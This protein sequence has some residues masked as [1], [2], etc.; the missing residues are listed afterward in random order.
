MNIA[1]A[2]YMQIITMWVA[3]IFQE[4][5]MLCLYSYHHLQYTSTAISLTSTKMLK[6][7][8]QH[9]T[10]R[11][12]A[13]TCYTAKAH[14]ILWYSYLMS[15]PSHQHVMHSTDA[16]IKI[17]TLYITHYI[18]VCKINRHFT[19]S[20]ASRM[21]YA[22]CILRRPVVRFNAFTAFGKILKISYLVLLVLA[23]NNQL[24]ILSQLLIITISFRSNT[25][26]HMTYKHKISF[27]LLKYL[28]KPIEET[29][30]GEWSI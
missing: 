24:F 10:K 15:Q 26:C 23:W 28:I 20:C 14:F 2:C 22:C 8:R 19:T 9:W 4:N 7:F 27:F 13:Y 18:F 25:N 3:K 17:Y 5:H 30:C 16:I 21:C 29:Q 12:H 11:E 1:D 6:H